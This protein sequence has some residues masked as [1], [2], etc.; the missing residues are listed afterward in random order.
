VGRR[1]RIT[2]GHRARYASKQSQIT[3]P[4]ARR[5]R[6][7]SS[8]DSVAHSRQR[9]QGRGDV[10]IW[11][12]GRVVPPGIRSS[13]APSQSH[14]SA[15]IQ[16]HSQR[17]SSDV[18]L[19]DNKGTESRS[20]GHQFTKE[21]I[22][23]RTEE[24]GRYK[25]VSSRQLGNNLG[26]NEPEINESADMEVP[27]PESYP[28]SSHQFKRRNPNNNSTAP[29][30]IEPPIFEVFSSSSTSIHHPMP[31]SSKV[32]VLLR[33][34]SSEAAQSTVAQVGKTKP[35]VPSSQVLDN[36]I[37]ETW[38]APLDDVEEPSSTGNLN[39]LDTE[40]GG[41]SISPGVSVSPLVLR[42]NQSRVSCPSPAASSQDLVASAS[43]LGRSTDRSCSPRAGMTDDVSEE[44]QLHSQEEL[45]REVEGNAIKSTIGFPEKV[46]PKGS[47][48]SQTQPKKS[49]KEPD[50]DEIWRKFV[51][52][53]EY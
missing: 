48:K 15:H 11:I 52:G 8:G 9:V 22:E 35:V 7:Q 25:G 3:S 32:S 49:G 18:M 46:G 33:S 44:E 29:N 47:H 26:Q 43:S 31:R 14:K 53:S 12:G 40:E 30:P 28:K 45:G 19:L 39:G 4:F 24:R 20:E 50:L 37:W 17:A 38:M 5:V 16:R 6:H 42:G 23:V 51:L 27:V 34:N 2:E 1:R 13:S 41:I 21:P 10:R 36:E